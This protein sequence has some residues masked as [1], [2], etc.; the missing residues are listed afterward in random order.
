MPGQQLRHT[1]APREAESGLPPALKQS[2]PVDRCVNPGQ[3]LAEAD[4]AVELAAAADPLAAA[5]LLQGE[6]G[7]NYCDAL[8]AEAVNRNKSYEKL[9][10]FCKSE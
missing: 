7:N 5:C 9:T 10:S 8:C 2:G 3:Q 1:A 4:P 6:P